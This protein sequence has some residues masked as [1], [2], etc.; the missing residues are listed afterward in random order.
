MDNAK[1]FKFC[2]GA[3]PDKI[4]GKAVVT[5]VVPVQLFKQHLAVEDEFKGKLYSGFTGEADGVSVTVIRSGIGD[6]LLG[7]A[8]MMLAG[9]GVKELLFLGSCGGL[10]ACEIGDIVIAEA[11]MNGEGFSRYFEE[12]FSID[13]LI[14]QSRSVSADSAM[15][16][17]FSAYLGRCKEHTSRLRNGNIFTIGS[18]T[19]EVGETLAAIQGRGFIG[20]E[21]ELSAVYRAA[22]VTGIS[23]AGLLVVSD[24]PVSKGFWEDAGQERKP[25]YGESIE[26]AVK[27]SVGFLC[28]E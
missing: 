4:S 15:V 3:D 22:K 10:S 14:D 17:A 11:A 23:A 12:T 21:M 25:A 6:R 27:C 19:A 8:V 9:A 28:R 7:D 13:R 1:L 26:A 5:P 16:N 20:I 18:L 2:F 24:L